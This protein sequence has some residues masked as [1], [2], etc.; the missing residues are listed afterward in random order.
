VDGALS[1]PRRQPMENNR[2]GWTY[3][4]NNEGVLGRA[5]HRVFAEGLL[6]VEVPVA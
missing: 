4:L 1:S 6:G 3:F 5:K 2:C